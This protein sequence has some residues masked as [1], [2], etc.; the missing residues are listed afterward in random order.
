MESK[1]QKLFFLTLLPFAGLFIGLLTGLFTRELGFSE[2]DPTL[3]QFFTFQWLNEM[4]QIEI[5]N[6]AL[7]IPLLPLVL[8]ILWDLR[9]DAIKEAF[10]KAFTRELLIYLAAVFAAMLFAAY[11]RPWFS[12]FDPSAHVLLKFQLAA[13]TQKVLQTFSKL[14]SF[15]TLFLFSALYSL[16]DAALIH[17]TASYCH[18]LLELLAGLGIGVLLTCSARYLAK[19]I[20]GGFV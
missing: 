15:R 19:K 16:S 18:T 9:Q 7:L 3:S 11:A 20:D 2:K 14:A 17:N 10:R 4:K 8:K 1:K 12:G 13:L 5:K 6:F